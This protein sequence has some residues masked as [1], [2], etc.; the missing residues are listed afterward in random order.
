MLVM[1]GHEVYEKFCCKCRHMNIDVDGH[2]HCYVDTHC[3]FILDV[4]KPEYKEEWAM[5]PPECPYLL[6]AMLL[7][8]REINWEK[9][10]E[11]TKIEVEKIQAAN[12]A[13]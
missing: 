3:L 8:Q 7:D 10:F 11:K 9:I 2:A 6:E 1:T 12:R 4:N 13:T 5:P